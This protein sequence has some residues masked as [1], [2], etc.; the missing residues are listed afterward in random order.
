M[1]FRSY[2]AGAKP[3]AGSAIGTT[4]FNSSD[5]PGTGVAKYH[6]NMTTTS[7]NTLQYSVLTRIRIK[8]ASQTIWDVDPTHLKAVY[9][10]L[11]RSNLAPAA[12]DTS[13]TL[14]M[15][16]INYGDNDALQYLGGFPKGL[17]PTL[18]VVND[19]TQGPGT[20][21]AGWTQSDQPFQFFSKVLSSQLNI[22][23]S[24]LN[25]RFPITQD[26]LIAGFS[27]NTT[28]LDRVRV[29]LSGI[30]VLN[31]SG[32]Q[33]LATQQLD[34]TEVVTN[35]IFIALE[36]PTGALG[37]DS[38]FELDTNGSWAGVSNQVTIYSILPNS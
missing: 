33:L 38:F 9:Q 22:P 3:V 13:F 15:G 8:A 21:L 28:G 16:K 26:G 37:G 32:A 4:V 25:A 29:K 2:N 6:I 31:I 30:E 14:H 23:A 36:F 11:G 27:I 10:R 35:P 12:T 19:G 20:M 18:E 24:V 5:I 1:I 7:G 34:N 17:A